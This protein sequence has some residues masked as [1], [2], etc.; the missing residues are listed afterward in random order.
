MNKTILN[1]HNGALA[2]LTS[3]I[4]TEISQVWRQIG[5]M[6]QEVAS[7]K[8]AINKLQEQTEA[9]VNGTLSTMDGMEIKVPNICQS[10]KQA[11]HLSYFLFIVYHF[12]GC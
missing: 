7:S 8:D 9:Y 1:N 5:S 4:E 6:F 3:K 12:L 10:Y 11:K 2:N